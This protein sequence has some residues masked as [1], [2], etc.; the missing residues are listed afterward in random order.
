MESLFASGRI[1]DLALAVLLAEAAL[2][3]LLYWRK[4]RAAEA[5]RLLPVLVAGACLLAA[6]RAAL[7]GGAWPVMALSLTGALLAHLA[8][9]GLRLDG[10]GATRSRR[11]PARERP[12]AE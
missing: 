10:P 8:D 1:V 3:S 12:P 2:L 6:L 5:L 9:L 4:G 11:G 7:T